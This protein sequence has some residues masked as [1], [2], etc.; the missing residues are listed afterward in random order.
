MLSVAEKIEDMYLHGDMDRN[1][2]DLLKLLTN[3]TAAG[4]Q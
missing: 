2:T 1:R 3:K 4:H